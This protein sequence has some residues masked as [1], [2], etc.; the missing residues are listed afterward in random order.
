MHSIDAEPPEVGAFRQR[1]LLN[2]PGGARAAILHNA[3][4]APAGRSSHRGCGREGSLFVRILVVDDHRNTLIAMSI[5][6]RRAGHSAA[7]A[8]GA[9][10]ALAVLDGDHFDCVVCDVR[11]PSVGGLELAQSIRRR[12]PSLAIVL[13]TAFDLSAAESALADEIGAPCLLKPVG[14]DALLDTIAAGAR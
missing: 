2:Q 14:V 10:E 8:G 1:A 3:P 4:Q 7:V 9:D 5:G 6:L 12:R 13:M 11:M